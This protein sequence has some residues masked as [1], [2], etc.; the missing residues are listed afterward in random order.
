MS[1]ETRQA[2]ATNPHLFYGTGAGQS[3]ATMQK[4]LLTI[5][6][7]SS[8]LY[9]GTQTTLIALLQWLLGKGHILE[10]TIVQT[11]HHNDGPRGHAGGCAFDFWPLKTSKQ[12]DWLDATDQRFFQLLYDI[13]RSE[14]AYQTGMTGDGSTSNDC[15]HYAAKGYKERG[16][17]VPGQSVFEDSGAPHLHAGALQ[18]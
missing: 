8:A 1:M 14:Y 17:Y 11:G 15:W 10:L 16:V 5:P 13:G 6:P 9:Q 4:D 18:P 12:D 3:K 2:V 7:S